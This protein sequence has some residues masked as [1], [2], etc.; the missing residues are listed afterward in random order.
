MTAVAQDPLAETPGP[1]EPGRWRQYAVTAG[2]L[3]PA[4]VLLT[5]WVVYPTVYTVYR[6]LFD[7]DGD[8]FID[9]E[10]TQPQIFD[11]DDYDR[12]A[13]DDRADHRAGVGDG[14]GGLEKPIHK[15]GVGD[16]HD[17]DERLPEAD[18]RV[19]VAAR[20]FR[21]VFVLMFGVAMNLHGN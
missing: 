18:G 8:K 2:F 4:A 5:V 11:R 14:V 10:A 1:G 19:L 6:S 9:A 16:E 3:L 15:V 21:S 7:R 17:A 12:R 13:E 20:A